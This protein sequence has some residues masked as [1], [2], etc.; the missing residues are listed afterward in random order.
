MPMKLEVQLG[1][2]ESN[3][4]PLEDQAANVLQPSCVFLDHSLPYVLR[5]Y[6]TDLGVI[7]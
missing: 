7:H 1:C 3:L 6:H 4:S 5:Q 2:W